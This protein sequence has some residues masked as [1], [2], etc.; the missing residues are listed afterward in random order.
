MRRGVE[1][2]DSAAR[3][4]PRAETASRAQRTNSTAAAWL[5]ASAS[6]KTCTLPGIIAFSSSQYA[7]CHHLGDLHAG[8]EDRIALAV[9]QL[10]PDHLGRGQRRQRDGAR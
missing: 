1:P 10:T 6:A 2:P 8:E 5:T 4:R 7:L 3:K 9:R